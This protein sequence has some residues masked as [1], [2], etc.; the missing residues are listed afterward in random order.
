MSQPQR[1]LP[2]AL[3]R[4]MDRVPSVLR[5]RVGDFLSICAQVVTQMTEIDVTQVH[6]NSDGTMDGRSETYVRVTVR[7]T[8]AVVQS[9]LACC[10]EFL[11]SSNGA[12]VNAEWA[13][14]CELIGHTARGLAEVA[15]A[16]ELQLARS[17]AV[18]AIWEALDM[19][20]SLRGKTRFAAGDMLFFLCRAFVDGRKEQFVPSFEQDMTTSVQARCGVTELRQQVRIC[21]SSMGAVANDAVPTWVGKLS[22]WLEKYYNTHAFACMRVVDRRAMIVHHQAMKALLAHGNSSTGQYIKCI[23]EV[24]RFF[25]GLLEINRRVLLVTHDHLRIAAAKEHLVNSIEGLLTSN[26]EVALRELEQA[27]TNVH[28]TFGRDAH[29]DNL[30]MTYRH[31]PTGRMPQGDLLGAAEAMLAAVDRMAAF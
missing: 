6:I 15:A 3:A 31:L 12:A 4:V 14:A 10:K 18:N 17:E 23:D 22:D 11:A 5:K 25:E 21:V 7:E 9:Y 8:T 27:Y 20:A 13:A 28:E 24:T 2:A 30:L 19:V 29:L 16:Q 26:T 1:E